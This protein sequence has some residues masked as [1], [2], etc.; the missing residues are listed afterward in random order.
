VTVFFFGQNLSLTKDIV[1]LMNVDFECCGIPV[2]PAMKLYLALN[3]RS[4]WHV[5]HF[6]TSL[7]ATTPNV[8]PSKVSPSNMSH[9]HR[10]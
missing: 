10:R 8:T 2:G 6:N 7:Q 3:L 4:L 5:F 1:S 9:S